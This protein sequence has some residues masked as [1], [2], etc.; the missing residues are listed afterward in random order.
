[1]V[2]ALVAT[3]ASRYAAAASYIIASLIYHMRSL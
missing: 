3:P 1:L 2:N